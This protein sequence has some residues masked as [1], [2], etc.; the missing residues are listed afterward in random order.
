MKT[1]KN[2]I[3]AITIVIFFILSMTTS[4]SLPNTSAHSPPKTIATYAYI[5]V[6]PN[7][8]GIDQSVRVLMWIDQTINGGAIEN[9]YRFHNSSSQL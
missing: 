9:D 1:I 2:K 4:I 3:A 6:S 7:P 5:V 8:V